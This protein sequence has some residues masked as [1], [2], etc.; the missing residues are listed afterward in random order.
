[1][2]SGACLEIVH[3]SS[4]N[5]GDFCPHLEGGIKEKINI[6]VKITILALVIYD[7]VTAGGNLSSAATYCPNRFIEEVSALLNDGVHKTRDV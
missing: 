3:F 7:R 5:W 4:R 6:I 1:L 2:A